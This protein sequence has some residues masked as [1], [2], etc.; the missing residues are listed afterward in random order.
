MAISSTFAQVQEVVVSK[1]N[2]LKRE[3]NGNM[4]KKPYQ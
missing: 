3:V 4:A 2:M 1:Q